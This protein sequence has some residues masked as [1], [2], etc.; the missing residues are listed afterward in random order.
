M[1]AAEPDARRVRA[2][3]AGILVLFVGMGLMLGTHVSRVP[4]VR[5]ALGVTPAQLGALFIAGSIGGLIAFSLLGGLVARLGSLLL[6][7]LASVAVVVGFGG[8]ALAAHLGSPAVFGA[9][10]FVTLGSFETVNALANAEAATVER[11]VG[12]SIMSQFHAAFALALLAGVGIGAL[13]SGAGVAVPVHYLVNVGV[14]GLAFLACARLAILD[15]A[16]A[17]ADSAERAGGI[18]VTLRVAAR[19]R[20]TL[21]LGLIIFCAF[22]IEM[23]ANNWLPLTLVD[24]FGRTEALAALLYAALVVA[25][26]AVRVVG[27]RLIDR[28]GRVRILRG[29]AV[30][31]AAGVLLIALAPGFWA[32]PIALLLWGAGAALG[33]PLAISAAADERT[34]A[35]ARVAAV[36][37]FGTIAG[38][39]MPQAIG[40]LAEGLGLRLSLLLVVAVAGAMLLLAPAARPL[41]APATGVEEGEGAADTLEA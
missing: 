2:A 14:V 32:V 30:L 4:S 16:P 27:G 34:N 18:F 8:M 39:T 11:M 13:Y 25:Q 10:M 36:A 35:T 17:A 28:L 3:R 5:D 37:A 9:A 15:G 7:R 40:L 23:S 41:P 1:D 38:L 12:R 31:V 22:T 26:S 6:L 29:S 20:R 21:A 33:Y 24:D 19:E